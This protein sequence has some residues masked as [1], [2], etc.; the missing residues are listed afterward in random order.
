MKI[1][2]LALRGLRGWPE[3]EF[4]PL[5][6]GLNG[7]S[8]PVG[9]G[10]TTLAEL[11]S[12]VVYGKLPTNGNL[13]LS[14]E[15]EAVAERDGVHF[16]LRRHHDGT[17]LGRLTV[18]SPDG[19]PVDSETVRRLVDGLPRDVLQRYYTVN[20]A[21]PPVD[22]AGAAEFVRAFQALVT[23]GAEAN[24]KASEL[25]ARR[26]ALAQELETRIAGERRISTELDHRRREL[27]R[28]I[29]EL[30]QAETAL[31]LRLRAVEMALAETDARLRYRRLE[32]NTELRW[33]IAEAAEWETQLAELDGEIARWRAT[34]ADLTQHP[35]VLDR[36]LGGDTDLGERAALES[37]RMAQRSIMARSVVSPVALDTGRATYELTPGMVVATLLPVLNTTARGPRHLEPRP[38]GA[39]GPDRASRVLAVGLRLQGTCR[40]RD[41]RDVGFRGPAR[42]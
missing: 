11:L 26:D 4:G 17:R 39:L 28:Q 1:T 12:H 31:E 6:A 24:R 29:R 21:T 34:L 27:D 20:F 16:R 2:S 7:F 40:H 15:G 8:G 3:L 41:P 10:K 9:S 5:A 32:L 35:G 19:E 33:Q 30:D 18:A 13:E 23:G 36:I 22:G 38:L 42:V 14:P 25:A 37:T